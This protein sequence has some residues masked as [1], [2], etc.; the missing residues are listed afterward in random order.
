MSRLAVKRVE[1][2]VRAVAVLAILSGIAGS[3]GCSSGSGA[4]SAGG[5]GGGGGA[6]TATGGKDG[7]LGGGGGAATGGSAGAPGGGAATGGT[8]LGGALG[9]GGASAPGGAHGFATAAALDPLVQAF[10]AASRACCKTGDVPEERLADCETTAAVQLD[11]TGLVAGR[12]TLNAAALAACVT[13]YQH[14]ATTCSTDEVFPA[15]RDLLTGNVPIGGTCS[16]VWDCKKD[17]GPTACF[18]T[19]VMTEPPYLLVGVC[20]LE[21]AGK[22]GDACM[23]S[24][25]LGSDCSTAFTTNTPDQSITLC[26]EK[27]GLYCNPDHVCAALSSMGGACSSASFGDDC[28]AATYCDEIN[29][30][31][32]TCVPRNAPG[33]ACDFNST[34]TTGYTCEDHRC[35]PRPLADDRSCTSVPRYPGT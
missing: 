16:H 32:P 9:S 4:R 22:M 27:D 3:L 25:P 8:G 10:C 17:Q 34:C 23:A 19:Q 18:A 2:H 20:R 15:C 13:A 35:A 26:H 7:A 11:T 6:M 24:C 12:A 14:A 5:N 28:P 33:A 21:P 31:T 30:P 1:S 29:P